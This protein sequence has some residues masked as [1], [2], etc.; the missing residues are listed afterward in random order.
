MTTPWHALDVLSVTAKL[1]TSLDGLS[2]DEAARR[3]AA[4]GPNRLVLP[5]TAS[6]G[7]I[8]LAQL[9]SVMVVLLVAAVGISLVSGDRLDALAIGAV[10]V[11]NTLI[12]F[13]TELRARRAMEALLQL[14]APRALVVRGGRR[15]EI[16]ARELV[17]GDVIELEAAQQVAAD[18]RLV[19]G[20]GSDRRTKR[21]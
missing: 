8:L 21:R 10:L 5:P 2:N 20:D 7:E 19:Q 14:D 4:I 17:P 1:E 15:R 9:R 11:I 16:D 18:A 6:I 12:G 3:L 13:V